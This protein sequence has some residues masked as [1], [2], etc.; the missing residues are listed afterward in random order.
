MTNSHTRRDALKLL[1]AG[2]A[3]Y[4]CEPALADPGAQAPPRS[5]TRYFELDQ[6]RLT[7]GPFLSAQRLDADYLLRLDPDRLLAN[8]RKNAGLEPRA[9]VYGG[10]GWGG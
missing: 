9:A 5:R 3:V 10:W 6:V 7:D 2:A 8:F 4:A 1:G